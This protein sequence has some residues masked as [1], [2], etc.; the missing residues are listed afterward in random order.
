M[1]ASP[2]SGVSEALQKLYRRNVHTIKLDLYPVR[3]VCEVLGD[4]QDQ[5]LS[6]HVA[7][8]NGKG[9]VT[10]MVGSVLRAAG[11]T[12]GVY[13][14]PHLIRFS[15]RL[16]VNGERIGDAALLEGMDRVEAAVSRVMAEGVRDLTFFEF[17]TAL[18]F[19]WFHR[20]SVHVAAVETGMGGRLDATN[21]MIPA[22]SVITSIG[23]EHTQY[24][25]S[26]LDK[27]AGEKAGIIKPGRPV[28]VGEL[29]DEA[30]E[31]VA[32]TARKLDAPLHIAHDLVSIR[33]KNQ[34]WSGQTFEVSTEGGEQGLVTLPFLGPHPAQN[35]AVALA[36]CLVLRDQ[37]GLPLAWEEMLPGLGATWLAAR[38]QLL[39][40][41]PVVILDGA[42][43]PPAA[44]VLAK[45]L[46]ECSR[47]KPLGMVVGFLSDKDPGSFMKRFKGQLASCWVVGMDSERALQPEDLQRQLLAA[48]I[49]SEVMVDVKSAL[50]KAR[51]WAEEEGGLVLITGSFYLAG[52]VLR[53]AEQGELEDF[54]AP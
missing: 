14:S 15:E 54:V 3:A 42:H 31:V 6:V 50:H 25:G 53:L 33:R 5:F 7:G 9:M 44:G 36:A 2:A 38:T 16:R 24:L 43:N 4:P 41:D 23:L 48:G 12:T 18:A 34:Q 17:T 40:T 37:V 39:H 13:S 49:E 21:V 8:T 51:R 30:M 28:V 22:V 32:R 27:I 47:N 10:E 11:L 29:P 1:S 26:T 46:K 19:D 45:T 35:L 20:Q 52:E